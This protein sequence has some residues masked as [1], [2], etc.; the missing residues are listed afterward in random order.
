LQFDR[1]GNLVRMRLRGI[2][3]GGNSHFTCR[4][5]QRDESVRFHDGITTGRR[6][7]KNGHL[8]DFVDPLELQSCGMRVAVALVYMLD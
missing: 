6:C 2:I 3:Y 4:Y 1:S 7:A 8:S 5:I